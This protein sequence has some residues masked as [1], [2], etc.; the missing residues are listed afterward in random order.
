MYASVCVIG[1]IKKTLN[2][3]NPNIYENADVKIYIIILSFLLSIKLRKAVAITK[4][5][6]IP[7]DD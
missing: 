4:I 3:T 2:T 6:K 7:S 5:G 1:C